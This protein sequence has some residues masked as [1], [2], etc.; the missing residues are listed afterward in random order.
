MDNNEE[1]STD[2]KNELEV[3]LN[4]MEHKVKGKQRMRF[5][6]FSVFLAGAILVI[7]LVYANCLN[8]VYNF[9]QNSKLSSQGEYY[10]SRELDGHIF[11]NDRDLVYESE[12]NNI[13]D[14]ETF[15]ERVHLYNIL[16]PAE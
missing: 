15:Y 11:L 7:F 8:R 4:R 14:E 3:K 16:F 10:F 9:E 6:A 5:S 1:L 12:I 13:P 2:F